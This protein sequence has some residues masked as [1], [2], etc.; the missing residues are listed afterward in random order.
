[1]TAANTP[2]QQHPKEHCGHEC[3]CGMYFEHYESQFSEPC[4]KEVNC[5]HDTRSRPHPAPQAPDNEKVERL[6]KHLAQL[7]GDGFKVISDCESL[8]L[9]T[10]KS[11]PDFCI[12]MGRQCLWWNGEECTYK[13][14][15]QGEADCVSWQKEH[16]AAIER[17]A[18][19][20]EREKM[21]EDICQ[22]CG[23]LADGGEQCKTCYVKSL[24]HHSEQQEQPR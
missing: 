12:L 7:K 14:S 5:P 22:N 13:T 19:E 16:D 20:D 6:K 21:L 18:R 24:R 3:V 4:T 15:E 2:E 1:M 10:V 8:I 23:G 17:K 11:V 9:D